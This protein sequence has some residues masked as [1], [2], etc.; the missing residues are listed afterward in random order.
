M[1]GR[2]V[3]V[4]RSRPRDRARFEGLIGNLAVTITSMS[5]LHIG[6]TQTI[7]RVSEEE[8]K[9]VFKT[10]GLTQKGIAE[11]AFE[12]VYAPFN[13]SAGCPTVPASSVKGNVRSRLELSFRAKNGRVRSCF[14]RASPLALEPR[15]GTHGWRHFKLWSGALAEDRGRPCDHTR[16]APVCLLCDLFGTAGLKGLVGFSDL[17]GEDVG[18]EPL[19]LE[20]DVRVL[21]APR[22]SKF[23]G[24]V[25]FSNLKPEELGLVLLGMGIRDSRTGRT[26][27]LGRFKYRKYVAKYVLGKVKYSLNSLTLSEFSEPLQIG[28]MMIKPGRCVEGVALDTVVS[29]LT[30]LSLD[31]FKGELEL[32]DE[33]SA[34]EQLS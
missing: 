5:Y 28:D 9:K 22:G 1:S 14:V 13:L 4:I 34:I 2:R 23:S 20:H 7:L 21:A 29:A 10:Y 11:I 18:L 6:S 27:L 31:A 3:E 26:V 25:S 19:D 32:V 15:T 24:S 17:V 33:A 16:G 30:S 8:V 12:E